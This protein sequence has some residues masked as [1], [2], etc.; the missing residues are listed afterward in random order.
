[1]TSGEV[2]E[3]TATERMTDNGGTERTTSGEAVR[4]TYRL[5][6]QM[7]QTASVYR[8]QMRLYAKSKGPYMFI[9]LAAM[10]PL[11]A[12]T[13]DRI[14]GGDAVFSLS[15]SLAL[16]PFMMVLI[17]AT[18]AG[19]VMS[20]EFKNRTGY[21][22]FPLPVSRTAFLMGKF[23]AALTL[24]LGIMMLAYGLAIVTVSYYGQTVAVVSDSLL[25]CLCGTFMI[26]AMACGL[27]AMFRRGSRSVVIVITL[28]LPVALMFAMLFMYP[29][30]GISEAALL[31]ILDVTVF[32]DIPRVALFA[33]DPAMIY[34]GGPEV[35]FLFGPTWFAL[36]MHEGKLPYTPE[37]FAMAS[38]IM[39][40]IFLIL[41]RAVINRKEM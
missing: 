1:M 38:V 41:G 37:M 6:S 36:D 17:P 8:L 29:Y 31:S 14:S 39:G 35:M 18:L 11:T 24:S 3:D 2:A 12:F 33:L 16:L 20:S 10:I 25:I 15:T 7:S 9:L 40:V 5:P 34:G 28:V 32:M 27:S 4:R 21:L 30:M 19:R 22:T 13:V 23:A 26:T